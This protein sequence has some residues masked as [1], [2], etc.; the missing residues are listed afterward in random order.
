MEQTYHID[1]PNLAYQTKLDLWETGFGLQKVD[2]LE[3]SVYM[4]NL[5]QE[6]IKGTIGY[7]KIYDEISSYHKKTDASTAEADL[8]ALRIVELLSNDAFKFAPTTLK[9]IHKELFWGLLPQG[10]PL[11]EY[12]P[13][14]ISKPEAIL[15]GAS[16][17]YDDYRTIAA[18]L[19]H[20]FD[21]EKENDY[22]SQSRSEQITSLR[23]FLS[24][25]WQIHPFGEGNTRT[26]TVFFIKYLRSMG[27]TITNEPFQRHAKYF[28]D[29]LVLDNAKLMQRRPEY[30]SYFFDHLFL[31]ANH[32]L[33]EQEMS[34]EVRQTNNETIN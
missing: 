18:S 25:I 30:L 17:I 4:K 15:G 13:Y 14:N 2:G 7:Q 26:V 33:S 24:G 16:V 34:R 23:K 8:V 6:H 12:R 29:A 19:N 3:P 20:D 22:L 10:I 5:A 32:Q 1:N 9:M 11:G 27:F 31:Q 21:K 28:R